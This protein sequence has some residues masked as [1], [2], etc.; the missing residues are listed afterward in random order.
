MLQRGKPAIWSNV[1]PIVKGLPTM[2]EKNDKNK[3]QWN[4]LPKHNESP[5][6]PPTSLSEE[7]IKAQSL[8]VIWFSVS[9]VSRDAKEM[10][11]S[12]QSQT[13]ESLVETLLAACQVGFPSFCRSIN[14]NAEY[15]GIRHTVA[16]M[17]KNLFL[18]T[19]PAA[20]KTA[21]GYRVS[22]QVMARLGRAPYKLTNEQ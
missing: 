5:K 3:M 14:E 8:C 9:F 2:A 7:W 12:L 15:H 4:W 19:L 10:I 22:E 20:L 17:E 13:G 11:R 21:Y 16:G 18:R 1:H 6:K